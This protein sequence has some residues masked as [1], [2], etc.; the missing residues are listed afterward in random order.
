MIQMNALIIVFMAVPFMLTAP[1]A[2]LDI[3]F[4]VIFAL[5]TFRIAM[6]MIVLNV[7]NAKM[8]IL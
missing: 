4:Q 5:F 8:D 7:Y 1:N 6:L 2:K 3:H